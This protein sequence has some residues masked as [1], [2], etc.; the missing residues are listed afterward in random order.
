[1]EGPIVLATLLARADLELA[2]DAEVVPD[3]SATLRP[4]GGVPMRV[5]AVAAA[6]AA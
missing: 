4:K 2:T 3:V 6:R 1:M 5:K